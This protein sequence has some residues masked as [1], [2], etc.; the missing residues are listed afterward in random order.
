MAS[1]IMSHSDRPTTP[2]ARLRAAMNVLDPASSGRR[3][4]LLT[5]LAI[6]LLFVLA[7]TSTPDG[8]PA[9]ASSAA[10]SSAAS[11]TARATSPLFGQ[12]PPL[13]PCELLLPTE[14]QSVLEGPFLTTEQETSRGAAYSCIYE[15]EDRQ[16]RIAVTV[17][18]PPM[19]LDEF[20]E[21][22]EQFD[23]RARPITDLGSP[24]VVVVFGGTATVYALHED[25][26][27]YIDV[28]KEGRTGGEIAPLALGLTE[29]ALARLRAAGGRLDDGRRV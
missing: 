27:F 28:V 25:V 2:R 6:P 14:I 17:R 5:F 23:Q 9:P 8:S 3:G 16:H 26:Q 21:R 22:M 15:T 7:C 24:A 10:G 1:T 19:T 18:K 4:A 11:P 13:D 29:R 12:P 20:T